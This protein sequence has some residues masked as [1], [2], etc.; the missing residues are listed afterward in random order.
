M[1][2]TSVAGSRHSGTGAYR[3][4][5]IQSRQA[6]T[7]HSRVRIAEALAAVGAGMADKGRLCTLKVPTTIIESR[8]DAVGSGST[9]NL[10]IDA[11]PGSLPTRYG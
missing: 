1:I 9:R 8:A 11:P 4:G 10:P 6:G 5:A 7:G 2:H 3:T